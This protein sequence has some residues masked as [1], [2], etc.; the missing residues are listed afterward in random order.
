MLLE[1]RIRIQFLTK[2]GSYF[3]KVSDPYL[4]NEPGFG[5]KNDQTHD[6]VKVS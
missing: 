4:V 1:L 5:F 6:E 2:F 3:I